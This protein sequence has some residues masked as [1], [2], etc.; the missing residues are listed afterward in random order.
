MSPFTRSS[1]VSGAPHIFSLPEI[2]RPAEALPYLKMLAE[3]DIRESTQIGARPWIRNP[4]LY[5]RYAEALALSGST[6]AEAKLMLE[7]AIEGLMQSD[8][9]STLEIILLRIH[10]AH[11]H[12][13]QNI[14]TTKAKEYAD[15]ANS[16]IHDLMACRNEHYVIQFLRKNPDFIPHERLK[17]ALI[18]PG[19]P[20]RHILKALGGSA[21]FD[22]AVKQTFKMHARAEKMCFTCGGREPQKTLSLCGGCQ[23]HWYCSK[24]CQVTD[25]KTHRIFCGGISNERKALEVFRISDPDRFQRKTDWMKWRV[26]PLGANPD[27]PIHAPGL[28]RDHSRGRT[29]IIIFFAKHTPHASR[30]MTHKFQIESAGVF[31]TSDIMHEFESM[32]DWAPGEGKMRIARILSSADAVWYGNEPQFP[33]MYILL[34]TGV[35][36]WFCA[37]IVPVSALLR[38]PYDPNWRLTMNKDEPV[39]ERELDLQFVRAFQRTS[40]PNINDVSA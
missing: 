37:S 34:C 40:F 11:V 5:L 36:P 6:D 35:T 22:K 12:R 30:D 9:R 26:G 39:A 28:Q 4:S 38:T 23:H 1:C 15:F 32:M 10:L 27:A 17:Q 20:E 8:A 16:F 24:P 25:W 3:E 31:R 7:H 33:A 21:W 13:C 29:H 14:Q 19:Q 18:R 2:D